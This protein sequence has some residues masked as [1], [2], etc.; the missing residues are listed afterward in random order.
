M[1]F[2][3]IRYEIVDHIA[4]IGLNRWPVNALSLEY[5]DE[6]IAALRQEGEDD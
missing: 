6:I 2:E 1:T 4:V 5:I 3:N